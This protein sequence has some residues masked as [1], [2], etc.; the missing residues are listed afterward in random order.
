VRTVDTRGWVSTEYHSHSSPSGDNTSSQYG[1]VL[2]LLCEHLEFAPCTE[3]QRLSTYS[4]HLKRLGVEHLLATCVGV[5]LTGQPLDS[6]HHNA[7]PLKLHEHEQHGGAPLIDADPRA[8]IQRLVYWDDKSD[9]LVQQ[10]HPNIRKVFFDRDGDGKDDGGFDSAEFMDVIEVHPP[11]WIFQGPVIKFG[12]GQE[13][14]NTIFQWMQ[15]LNRG[16]R[17]PGVVNTDAHYNFHG[18]GWVR[19]YV[20]SSTDDPAKIDV[21]EMVHNS[22]KGHIVMS[23]GP[24][25]TVR[26][27]WTNDRNRRQ[28][29]AIPGGDLIASDGEVTLHVQVQC[30]NWFDINRVQVFV[31]GRPHEG[32]NFTRDTHA[33]LFESDTTVRFKH[34]I[35]VKLDADAH[36]IVAAA[37]IGLKLGPVMGP[38]RGNDMPIA[39]SNPIF[40]DVDGGGFKP[41]GDDLGV[42]FPVKE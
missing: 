34:D 11:A 36:L 17:I 32:L 31:N 26:A 16:Y 12:N 9:K 39:V 23:T 28:R 42:P 3:H 10:N 22:E 18:S 35:A 8:Q 6:N 1:R 29:D 24:F 37:G 27:V 7:F 30:P 4:P 38:S 13:R 19:N 20:K 33:A 40:V 2:N 41:N 15:T 14:G 21:M 25:M 5:E